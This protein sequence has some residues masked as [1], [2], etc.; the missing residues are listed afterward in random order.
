MYKLVL[1]REAERFYHR[2]DKPDAAK[3]AR[4]FAALEQNPRGGNNVKQLKGRL[5]GA[6]RY[7]VG[8]LR[9]VYTIDDAEATV[10]VITIAN[11]REV[12]E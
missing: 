6:Y 12:Y 2:S 1:S 10:F 9:V 3:L 7:R 8:N 4:C 11:R 5:T